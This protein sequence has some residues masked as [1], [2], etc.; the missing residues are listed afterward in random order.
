MEQCQ[1]VTMLADN[2]YT[3]KQII[4]K[5]VEHL[6]RSGMFPVKE[7][8]DW[9]A[10]TAMTYVLL[11]VHFYKAY[12]RCLDAIQYGATSGQQGYVNANQYGAFNTTEESDDG[13]SGEETTVTLAE[14]MVSADA[15]MERIMQTPK[16]WRNWH[17]YPSPTISNSSHRLRLHRRTWH[18]RYVHHRGNAPHH[19]Q[20]TASPQ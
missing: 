1:E 8:E 5:T 6:K 16:S 2:P 18:Q 17:Q 9:G 11:K 15:K 12:T 10:V 14:A 3:E 7:F 4:T 13:S 19:L 20:M